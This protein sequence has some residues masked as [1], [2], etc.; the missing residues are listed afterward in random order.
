MM[1]P[2]RILSIRRKVPGRTAN[3]GD[4]QVHILGHYVLHTLRQVSKRLERWDEEAKLCEDEE[5]QKQ[6]LA[7]I[8]EKGFHCQGGAVFA[9]PYPEW[10]G[11]LLDL[12]VAIR[13][14]VITWITFAIEPI[15]KT[16]WLFFNYMNLCSTHCSQ[17]DQVRTIT[18]SLRLKMI[19]GT[20]RNWFRRVAPVFFNFHPMHLFNRMFW[21]WCTC[22]LIY[23]C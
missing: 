22:I 18:H 16:V 3:H 12:I 6:A 4:R 5:L 20:S 15:V 17:K 7:S 21:N 14:C 9:V 10:E 11:L 19:M 23:R 13:P 2:G 8:R 1:E